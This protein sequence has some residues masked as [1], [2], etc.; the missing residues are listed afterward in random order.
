MRFDLPYPAL[1]TVISGGSQKSPFS[2]E[3]RMKWLAKF[4]LKHWR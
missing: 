4:S 3:M 1:C 2:V